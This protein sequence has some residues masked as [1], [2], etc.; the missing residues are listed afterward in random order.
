MS[1]VA[2]ILEETIQI[3]RAY[4]A[5]ERD[6]KHDFNVFSLLRQEDDEVYLH[7]RFISELLSPDGMHQMGS[8]FLDL[9]LEQIGIDTFDVTVATVQ[10]EYHNIDIFAANPEQAII[11]ENKIYAADQPK[12]LQRYYQAIKK[13]GFAQIHIVYLT[14]YGADPGAESVGNLD[15]TIVNSVSY[16][17]DI[18]DWLVRC[19]EV[20]KP[21]PIITQTI[22]QYQNLVEKLTG[23]AQGRHLMDVKALLSD[24]EHLTAAMTISQALHA[25]KIDLQFKFWLTLEEKLTACGYD[26]TEYWKYSRRSVEA[27]YN[28]GVRRYG[29][30]FTLPELMDQEITAFFIGVSHRIYYGFIPLEGGSPMSMMND[31]GFELLSDIL[32][33]SDDGWSS[34]PTMLGWRPSQRC[35]DF[36]TFNTPDTLALID[37]ECLNT[38]LDELVEEIASVIDAF[39]EACERDPRLSDEPAW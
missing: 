10:R 36:Y 23:Q 16:Q 15:H 3:N 6:S 21:Y 1:V 7:S 32:K 33:T 20:A 38:Y 12:Q 29:I 27:Y 28:K 30:L 34:S 24:K 39:Y 25:F 17:V 19:Q 14:L 8:K 9:F 2:Q 18:R 11:I 35:F 37:V 31:P 4:S 13:E 5:I 26:I 22:V